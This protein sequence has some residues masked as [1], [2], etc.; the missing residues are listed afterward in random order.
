M[1]RRR[2]CTPV[3]RAYGDPVLH[4]GPLGAGQGVKRVNNAVFAA[5]IGLLADAVRLGAQFG[6]AAETGPASGSLMPRSARS[7]SNDSNDAPA[8]SLSLISVPA[9]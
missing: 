8:T 7:D 5:N 1:R 2:R 9:K 6:V 4:V 3:L